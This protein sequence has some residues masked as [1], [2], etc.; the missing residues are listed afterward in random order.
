[1]HHAHGSFKTLHYA[2]HQVTI[3]QQRLLIT[4]LYAPAWLSEQNEDV[5]VA[6]NRRSGTVVRYNVTAVTD[7]AVFWDV[8]NQPGREGGEG[9]GERKHKLLVLS[10]CSYKGVVGGR[11]RGQQDICSTAQH[12]TAQHSTAQHSTAQ[13]ST[14]Q[15]RTH[16]HATS[17]QTMP[18]HATPHHTIPR[19]TTPRPPARQHLQPPA[20]RH[21]MDAYKHKAAPVNLTPIFPS[22]L[23]SLPPPSHLVRWCRC[24]IS[25]PRAAL[26]P[27]RQCPAALR[28]WRS[29]RR[30]ADW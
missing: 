18:R 23:P 28:A 2:K 17:C 5:A 24:R 16:C 6:A 21:A 15:H 13:R 14:A 12:S 4:Y 22:P 11:I 30:V 27:V 8:N 3:A 10:E 1:M 19:Q 26:L 7:L 25:A 29:A 20:P 9:A